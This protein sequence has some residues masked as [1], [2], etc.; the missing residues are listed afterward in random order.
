MPDPVRDQVVFDR[1]VCQPNRSLRPW[2]IYARVLGVGV[3]VGV[4]ISMGIAI[5][6]SIGID[7]SVGITGSKYFSPCR[8]W[9]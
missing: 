8:E 6:I 3:G 4:A 5:G 1:E 9:T 7:L 2:V